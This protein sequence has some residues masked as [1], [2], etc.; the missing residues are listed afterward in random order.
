MYKLVAIDLDGTLLNSDGEISEENKIALRESI[1]SGKEVVIASGRILNS[2]INFS[3]QIGN[4]NYAISGNGSLVYDLNNEKI[5][6]DNNMSKEKVLK[7]V[8]ICEKNSIYYSIHT[9]DKIIT[10]SLN[11]N[12]LVYQNENMRRDRYKRV[13]I[14]VWPD[15][16]EFIKN[17]TNERF[18][19][20]SI[21]DDDKPIFANILKKLREIKGIDVLDVAHMSRKSI[22][23]ANE[24]IP[25]EYYYTEITNENV[26]KWEAIKCLLEKL[27]IDPKET[28]CI[29]DNYND[30]EMLENSGLGVAMSNANPYIK[31]I[32]KAIIKD[33][34]SS[35]IADILYSLE[36]IK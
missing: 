32:A 13:N 2:V 7:I 15:V 34:N 35:G 24:I 12:I 11:Y 19:K 22:K 1:K 23:V 29:G 36:R 16:Y 30:K 5:V 14:E 31:M 10:K 3:K 8:E 4:L 17:S 25:I 21:C 33:N 18:L 20:M 27:S 6:Y 26:N 28:I 9:F